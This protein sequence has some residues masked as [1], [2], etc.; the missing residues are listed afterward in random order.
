M[1]G[2]WLIILLSCAVPLH[3]AAQ[4]APPR[5]SEDA[6]RKILVSRIDQGRVQRLNLGKF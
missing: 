4:S 2:Y 3:V 6:A 1:N 5:P